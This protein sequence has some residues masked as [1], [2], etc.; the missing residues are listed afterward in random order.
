MLGVIAAV[1]ITIITLL[2]TGV[3]NFDT[4]TLEALWKVASFWFYVAWSMA[5]LIALVLSMKH[6]F[7]RSFAGYEA[8]MLDC[9]TKERL[10]EVNIV[11]VL[12]IWRKFLFWLIW[13][14]GFIGIFSVAVLGFELQSLGGIKV[15]IAILVFGALIIQ[16]ILL[17]S[18]NVRIRRS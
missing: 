8:I 18:R 4:Q 13:I 1:M 16:P 5:F 12:A 6:L 15:F 3:E 17:S 9:E 10:D 7:L 2:F 11:N 14:F